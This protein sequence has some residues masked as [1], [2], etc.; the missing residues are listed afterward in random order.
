MTKPAAPRLFEQ[1]D[2]P[3]FSGGA[4]GPAAPLPEVISEPEPAQGTQLELPE[5]E[6]NRL[7]DIETKYLAGMLGDTPEVVA[8]RHMP[9]AQREAVS[10]RR[11]EMWSGHGVR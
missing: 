1:D 10:Q 9:K 5:S 4:Y 6:I 11:R 2:L 3:L 7:A 8:L